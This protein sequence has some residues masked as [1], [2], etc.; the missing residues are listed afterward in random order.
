MVR[1]S[2]FGSGLRNTSE[3]GKKID[4]IRCKIGLR[5]V[6]SALKICIEGFEH[7]PT[8]SFSRLDSLAAEKYVCLE[9]PL[10]GT[11]I[12]FQGKEKTLYRW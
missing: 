5:F 6:L 1:G 2:G 7:S 11:W 9:L 12:W 10:I 8:I 3:I 4:K